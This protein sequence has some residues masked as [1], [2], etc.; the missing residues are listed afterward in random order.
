[1]TLRSMFLRSNPHIGK[2]FISYPAAG[3]RCISILPK[4]P[5]NSIFASGR[6]AFM[7]LAID[8]A[9]NMCPP[10]PPPLIMTLSSFCSLFIFNILFQMTKLIIFLQ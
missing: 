7:A 2:P 5:T 3:T 8:T 1:M 9:G 6:F 10:V 4:A